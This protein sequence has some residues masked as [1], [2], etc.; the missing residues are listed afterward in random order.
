MNLHR[1]P[2]HTAFQSQKGC[3]LNRVGSPHF[4]EISSSSDWV[5]VDTSNWINDPNVQLDCAVCF[6]VYNNIPDVATIQTCMARPEYS[7]YWS[8]GNEPD[9]VGG[10]TP[11]QYANQVTAQKQAILTVD[12]K[13]KFVIAVGT[14]LHPVWEPNSWGSQ[15]L[16]L[17]PNL[18]AVRA[19]Q[20]HLYPNDNY[21]IGDYFGDW[22]AWRVAN[23][24]TR[25]LWLME[26]GK[27]ASGEYNAYRP[28]NIATR[29][30]NNLIDRWAWYA[31]YDTGGYVCLEDVNGLTATGQEYCAL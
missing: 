6:D 17:L 29:A 15:M 8:L 4:H 18:H 26:V 3:V 21:A 11:Q 27:P 14:Y 10:Q 5:R 20:S 31:Q 7:G 16:A 1:S 9:T 28:T 30:S 23:Y 19:F 25:E 13:A 24:P 12:S 2:K 22:Q